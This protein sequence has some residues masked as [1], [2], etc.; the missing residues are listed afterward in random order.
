MTINQ[1]SPD[2]M[3]SVKPIIDAMT[4]VDLDQRYNRNLG[5]HNEP[6]EVKEMKKQCVHIVFDGRDY[7]LSV[8]KIDNGNLKCTVCGREI[9]TKF[10][11]DAV[12][13]LMKAIT[14]LNGLTMFG[15]LNGL[16]AAP[17]QTL[18]SMKTAMPA[19]AQLQSELNEFVSKTD[20]NANAVDNLGAEYQTPSMFNSI[21]R[22]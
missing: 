17:L 8:K 11:K 12:D 14:I 22:M 6:H 19:V 1:I 3:A 18:I 15:L 2:V 9:N 5:P 16:K 10:D 21:T 7:H 13:T 4:K 20:Q